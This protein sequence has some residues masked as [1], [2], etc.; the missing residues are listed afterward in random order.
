M[1]RTTEKRCLP[2]S[3]D[4]HQCWKIEQQ[5]LSTGVWVYK[6]IIGVAGLTCLKWHTL[7][8]QSMF[9]HRMGFVELYQ[10]WILVLFASNKFENYIFP[11]SCQIKLWLHAEFVCQRWKLSSPAGWWTCSS[12]THHLRANYQ[13][14][15]LSIHMEP[16]DPEARFYFTNGYVRSFGVAPTLSCSMIYIYIYFTF[17]PPAKSKHFQHTVRK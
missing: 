13:T 6:E 12:V 14:A 2:K 9:W 17:F 8:Q 7:C 15:C 10:W 16:W 1:R 5:C 3:V 11:A 4:C